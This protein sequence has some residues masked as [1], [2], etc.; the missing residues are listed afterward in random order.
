[1]SEELKEPGIKLFGK[2][3]SL[4]TRQPS[5]PDIIIIPPTTPPAGK[6]SPSDHH[7]DSEKD[8]STDE[9]EEEEGN[10]EEK[11]LKKPDKII[12]CQR[13]NSMETK[14]C[15]YN[16]YNINQPRHFCKKCQ[17]YWTAGGNMRNVPVGSG[18]RKNKIPFSSSLHYPPIL[19]RPNGDSDCSSNSPAIHPFWGCAALGGSWNGRRP[20][21][22][23][24]T[25]NLAL[26]LGKHSREVEMISQSDDSENRICTIPKT[27]RIDD[28]IEAA[29]S[30]IWST[31]GIIDHDSIIN[32]NRE[33][34]GGRLKGLPL[35]IDEQQNCSSRVEPSL[36][37]LEANPAAMIRSVRFHERS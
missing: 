27:M 10:E 5:D 28:P 9:E 1:M 26:A 6:T 18:R 33:G 4:P 8:S 21:N 7:G 15:Y 32:G 25:L 22:Y 29:R 31:L 2:S 3:I 34:G 13:C 20:P 14:F 30:S 17:R 12:P 23:S 36:I 37:V 19:I 11:G 35:N 24:T 16:N